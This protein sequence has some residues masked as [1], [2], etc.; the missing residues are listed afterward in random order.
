MNE[1]PMRRLG[2]S[3]PS[4]KPDEN[5][6]HSDFAGWLADNGGITGRERAPSNG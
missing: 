1:R 5:P 3:R 2:I 4:P 6:G